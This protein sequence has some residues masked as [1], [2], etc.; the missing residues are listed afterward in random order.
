[1]KTI[2]RIHLDRLTIPSSVVVVLLV[3]VTAGCQSGPIYRAHEIPP[4]FM[5]PQVH[6]IRNVDFSKLTRSVGNSDVLQPGDLVSVAIATGL[7]SGQTPR[8]QGQIGD[9]GSVSV[10][11]VGAVSVAG[12][13]VKT[14][15]HA[16]RQASIERGKFVDPSVSV[17]LEKQKANRVTVV[18]AVE[19]PGIYELPVGASD[20]LAAIVA[21]KGFSED[22]EPIVEIRHPPRPVAP[23]ANPHGMTDFAGLRRNQLNSIPPRTMRVDLVQLTPGYGEDLRLE[24]GSTVTVIQRPKRYFH[25]IGNVNRANQYEMPNDTD[26]RLLDALAMAGNPATNLAD[27]IHV[28]R[29]VQGRVEPAV[30]EISLKE[31]KREGASNLRLSP[32]DVVSV[33]ETPLTFVVGTIERLV[34]FGIGASVP[35]F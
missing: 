4:E 28:I 14:A 18:G 32:G 31:A 34:N 8:W 13:D 30:I 5:A 10:P 21:A 22:A 19:S 35:L 1:M 12:L 9:D 23:S 11:L 16:I 26:V 24:D 17:V 6:S 3:L 20:V 27:K 29:P 25:V 33:E 2:A 7:E 15:V